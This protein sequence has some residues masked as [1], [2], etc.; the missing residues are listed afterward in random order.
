MGV[1]DG[2]EYNQDEEK[3]GTVEKAAV[4]DYFDTQRGHHGA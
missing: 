3:Q 1:V 4:S 2:A